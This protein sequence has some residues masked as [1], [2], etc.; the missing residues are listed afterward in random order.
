MNSGP[1][2]LLEEQ[3]VNENGVHKGRGYIKHSYLTT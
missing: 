3:R 2:E 1:V